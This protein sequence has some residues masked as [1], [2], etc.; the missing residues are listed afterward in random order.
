MLNGGG[1]F[2]PGNEPQD[3]VLVAA[4]RP[5]AALLFSTAVAAYNPPAALAEARAWF[6]RLGLE[7]EDAGVLTPADAASPEVTA[8][9]EAAGLIYLAGGDP[10]HLL[11]VLKGS[12]CW[13]AIRR[14]YVEGASLAGSSAG[15]MV[16]AGTMLKPA[17]RP[18]WEPV[19]GLGLVP[20]AAI[21]PHFDGSFE[22][23][24]GLLPERARAVG[25]PERTAAVWQGGWSVLG[26][27]RVAVMGFTERASGEVLD[28]LP[29][30]C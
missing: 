12:R 25:I 14:A 16:L 22:R 3:A 1:E 7:M 10:W 23:A 2:G 5:G 21:L 28:G 27:G 11:R 18:P 30:P 17:E 8:R 13:Q 6:S 4:R 20:R 9:V 15:A 29:A 19:E 26:E 24:S